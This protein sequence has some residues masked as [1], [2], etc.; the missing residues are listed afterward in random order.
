MGEITWKA[1]PNQ[2][3]RPEPLSMNNERWELALTRIG[4]V[5]GKDALETWKGEEASTVKFT[6]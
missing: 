6:R 3:S 5:A 1:A 4:E 2:R